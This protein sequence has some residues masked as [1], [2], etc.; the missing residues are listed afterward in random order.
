M[1]AQRDPQTITGQLQAVLRPG[2]AAQQVD[3]RGSLAAGQR[4][5]Q[6]P[7]LLTLR[8][9]AILPG[10]RDVRQVDSGPPCPRV[11]LVGP[12]RRSADAV[13]TFHIGGGE[14]EQGG[15]GQFREQLGVEVL[16]STGHRLQRL[17]GR[18]CAAVCLRRGDR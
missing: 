9:A 5:P 4:T 7:A 2:P 10:H 14:S 3:Y 8:H 1:L 11:W 6:L 12:P 13:G 18:P 17:E 15:S 16:E